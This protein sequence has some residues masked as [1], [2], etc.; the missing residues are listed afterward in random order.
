[1]YEIEFAAAA[2]TDLKSLDDWRSYN[3]GDGDDFELE[4]EATTAN[5]ALMTFLDGRRSRGPRI[6][7]AE[8]KKQLGLN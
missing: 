5:Q 7:L 6:P 8:V 2:L 3:V 4:V 1:M